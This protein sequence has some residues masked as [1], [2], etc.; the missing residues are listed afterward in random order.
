MASLLKTL[1]K[2]LD[3]CM[4]VIAPVL[5]TTAYKVYWKIRPVDSNFD[6]ELEIKK[7]YR[8]WLAKRISETNRPASVFE[9]G[10][11]AGQNLAVAS[12]FGRVRL[13]GVD[14]NPYRIALGKKMFC[15][16]GIDAELQVGSENLAQFKNNE[17][18]V[19]FTCA[20]LL[21]IGDDKIEMAVS[22]LL[23]ITR[24]GI[25]LVEFHDPTIKTSAARHERDGYIRNYELLFSS[26]GYNPVVD[27]LPDNLF[28]IAGKWPVYGYS[29][30]VEKM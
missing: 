13:A 5:K 15:A 12:K 16:G 14:F 23:R 17:F 29:I 21:Y 4:H 8:L 30:Y 28:P 7:P 19:S 22:E 9:L 27:K 20:V 18:D 1:I 24:K 6:W 2:V 11:G 26:L 25:W 3:C 10:C